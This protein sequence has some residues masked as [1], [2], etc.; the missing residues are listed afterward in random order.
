MSDIDEALYPSQAPI[1]RARM[2]WPPTADHHHHDGYAIMAANS[3]ATRPAPLHKS[4]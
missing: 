2:R 1:C 3:A 4:L